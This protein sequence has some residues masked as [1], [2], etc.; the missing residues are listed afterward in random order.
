[1]E[2]QNMTAVEV[3][4]GDGNPFLLDGCECDNTHEQNNTVCLWCW[5]HGRRVPGDAEIA[6]DQAE[7][8][9]SDCGNCNAIRLVRENGDVEECRNCG[10]EE[11]NVYEVSTDVP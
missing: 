4:D 8:T 3:E 9:E 1:M 7:P 11:Y 10:D 2:N 6:L 5:A